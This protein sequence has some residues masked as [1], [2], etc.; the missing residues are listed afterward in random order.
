M[1][2][3]TNEESIE[4][5]QLELNKLQGD[6]L[7]C[8]TNQEFSKMSSINERIEQLEAQIMK[9]DNHAMGAAFAV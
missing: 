4:A 1:S 9:F 5:L 3:H 2:S 7:D 8:L 6:F